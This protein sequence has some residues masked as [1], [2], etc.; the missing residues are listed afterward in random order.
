MKSLRERA[1]LATKEVQDILGVSADTHPKEIADALEQAIITALL[2]ERK[3]CADVAF[4]CCI[5]DQDKAHQV[6]DE[7]KRVNTALVANLSSLR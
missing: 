2:E 4:N 5:E 7:I 3:R 1:E 6:A